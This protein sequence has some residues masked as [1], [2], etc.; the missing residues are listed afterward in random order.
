MHEK[1]S[2]IMTTVTDIARKYNNQQNIHLLDDA[3]LLILCNVFD[4]PA[5]QIL[6]LLNGSFVNF[7]DSEVCV[8]WFFLFR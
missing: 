6:K 1:M 2:K 7:T 8:C 3:S 4:E 5:R